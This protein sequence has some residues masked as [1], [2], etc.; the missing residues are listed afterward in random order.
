MELY[1]ACL[2]L[3]YGYEDFHDRFEQVL[4]VVLY[5]R[6][7]QSL[8]GNKLDSAGLQPPESITVAKNFKRS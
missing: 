8:T 6:L 7:L 2:H 4:T 3:L 5:A 1:I